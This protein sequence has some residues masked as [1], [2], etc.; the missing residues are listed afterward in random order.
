MNVQA[1]VSDMEYD[2][3]KLQSSIYDIPS[4]LVLS[5]ESENKIKTKLDCD[6]HCQIPLGE[7]VKKRGKEN[8]YPSS[9][10]ILC[11]LFHSEL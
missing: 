8:Q 5:S 7:Y 11:Y 1:T 3:I 10:N 9:K 2:H 4:D 6:K